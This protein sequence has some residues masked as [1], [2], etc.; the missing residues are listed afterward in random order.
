MKSIAVLITVHNRKEKTLACLRSLY[1]CVVPENHAF[2]VYLTDDGCTDGTAEAVRAGF[3][4]VN[5]I[6]GDGNL[7]W[8]RGMRLAWETAAATKDYDYYLWLNDDIV[9]KKNALLTLIDSSQRKNDMVI[10]VGTTSTTD[11]ED[12]ITY[13]GRMK[14]LRGFS[15]VRPHNIELVKCDTFNGNIVLIPLYVYERIG[16]NDPFFHH[17]F[18][19]IEYGLRATQNKIYSYIT[20]T[21]LG[22][23]NR[24]N[25]IP[26]FQRKGTFLIERYRL[27]YSPIGFN[28]C[29]SFYL[30]YKYRSLLYAVLLFIKLHI[31]VLFTKS[32]N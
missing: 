10:I 19:D 8:N 22:V 27:L 23:C 15:F 11:N 26:M 21:I 7:F 12:V 31:N 17:S 30:N 18:G 1:K 28:P 3:P 6:K 9:L 2:D 20:P 4:D 5:I 25:P 32:N 29:E 13:G 16:M 14:Q 24:N